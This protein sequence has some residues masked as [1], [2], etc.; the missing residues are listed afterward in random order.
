MANLIRSAKSRSDWTQAE[1]DAYNITIISQDATTFFGVPHLPQPH[2]SQ[3]LLAKESAIDMVDDKNTELI[4]LLDLAMVP[5]PE[6]SA[7]D[8]FA[9]KLFN[10]LGYVRRHRVARTR[11]DIPLLICREW[12]HSKTDVCILDREQNDITLL[13]QED[14]HFGL[15]ELSCTDAE[16][17]LITMC[18]A[19]FSHNNRHRVDAGWPERRSNVL[20]LRV[21][22]M[23]F[24]VR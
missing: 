18:I 19:A 2:V 16:A 6:D 22:S 13:L 4:N 3:E 5:S 20:T 11:K 17:Q 12:R 9:V 7:V 10:T 14:K 21:W 8:D 15:G 24:I 1:L 23:S